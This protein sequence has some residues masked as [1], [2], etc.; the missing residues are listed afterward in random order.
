[1]IVFA[2]C[3]YRHV[4]MGWLGGTS[5]AIVGPNNANL[6]RG[7]GVSFYTC[8][9]NVVDDNLLATTVGL[10]VSAGGVTGA[11]S[12]DIASLRNL[13]L[14]AQLANTT[15]VITPTLQPFVDVLARR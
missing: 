1:M 3:I 5:T 15:G 6:V 8:C 2:L 7:R 10:Y 13:L 12:V 11:N 9:G 14:Q 4:R